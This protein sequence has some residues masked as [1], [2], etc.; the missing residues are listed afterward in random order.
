MVDEQKIAEKDELADRLVMKEQPEQVSD[1]SMF[2]SEWLTLKEAGA[3][4]DKTPRY[5]RLLCENEHIDSR[6][7]IGG[8]FGKRLTRCVNR[9]Q[10]LN[11]V[12]TVKIPEQLN[13]LTIK[14]ENQDFTQVQAYNFRGALQGISGNISELNNKLGNISQQMIDIVA[15]VVEQGVDL[16]EKWLQD[17]E[18]RAEIE[19][20]TLELQKRQSRLLWL[21]YLILGLVIMALVAIGI[22]GFLRFKDFY[23]EMQREY[24]NKIGM[25]EKEIDG[26][27]QDFNSSINR[28]NQEVAILGRE[29]EILQEQ[30]KKLETL[31]QER[32]SQ[33]KEV[34]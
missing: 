32:W 34:E 22:T 33:R 3:I 17:R 9:K 2:K 18:K 8:E 25:Q 20:K 23:I 27:V 19:L 24:T 13:M 16:K 26:L 14:P 7:F 10:F 12:R 15:K 30:N 28:H 6:T 21:P 1:W 5:I 29:K 31:L 4:L 11:Y